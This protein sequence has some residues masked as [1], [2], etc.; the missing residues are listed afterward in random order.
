MMCTSA[1]EITL[2]R[3]LQVFLFVPIR[4]AVSLCGITRAVSWRVYIVHRTNMFEDCTSCTS[5]WVY[6]H[7]WGS[8]V[9]GGRPGPGQL[10]R[11]HTKHTQSHIWKH[12][13]SGKLSIPKNLGRHLSK[14]HDGYIIKLE[15]SSKWHLFAD[16]W[17]WIMKTLS[18]SQFV[19]FSRSPWSW[20]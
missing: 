20:E 3:L 18:V 4:V 2:S 1:L 15:I 19:I 6:K 14:T 17:C 10:I 8:S 11:P 16:V 5:W 13:L 9:V 12:Q 7:V